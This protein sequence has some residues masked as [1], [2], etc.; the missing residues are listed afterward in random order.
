MKKIMPGLVV[1]QA[2]HGTGV[3]FM[4]VGSVGP[5]G[6]VGRGVAAKHELRGV[7]FSDECRHGYLYAHPMRNRLLAGAMAVLSPL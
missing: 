3:N 6:L 1:P 5:A 7:G 2:D 4:R